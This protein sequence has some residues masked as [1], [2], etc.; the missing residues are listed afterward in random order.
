MG[1]GLEGK[2]ALITGG[3]T[4]IGQAAALVFAR[5]GASVVGVA[6]INIDGLE[7]TAE[8]VRRQQGQVFVRQI[9]V[10]DEQQV[11][12][13]VDQVVKTYGRLDC[14]FNNAGIDGDPAA[15][16]DCSRDVWSRVI[17]VNLTGVWLCMKHEIPRML[18]QGGGS[19]VNTSSVA[20]HVG[21]AGYAA[22]AASKQGLLGL[23]RTAAIEYAKAGI[24]VNAICPGAIQTPMLDRLI[25]DR[26]EVK[27]WLLAQ[28]PVGRFGKPQEVAEAAVWLCSDAASF[29]TGHTMFVDGG[30]TVQ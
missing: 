8:M 14:A 10:T 24:R 2:V 27:Q 18:E 9:D 13:M 20:G 15:T 28:E 3:S 22:Y 5:E 30:L 17:D 21:L 11:R 23:T 26:E 6:D 4:G 7:Q 1:K 12:E 19:I 29:V 25:G 16:A